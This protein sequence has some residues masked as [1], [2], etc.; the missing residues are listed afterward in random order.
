MSERTLS[1]SDLLALLR[2]VGQLLQAQHRQAAIYVVGGAAMALVFDARRVTRDVDMLAL[3][4]TDA[5]WASAAEVGRRH[6]LPDDWVNQNAAAFL[7]NEPD[8]S[9]HEVSLP[10]LRVLVASPEHLIAMKLRA[11]RDRDL[12][13]LD[14][15]FRHVGLTTPEQAAAIHDALFDESSIGFT[16]PEE[17]RYAAQIVFDR[18]KA[19]GN[20]IGG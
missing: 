6:S 1:G 13:D 2:E 3:A 12:A 18:A 5:F 10:G 11:L 14:L 15:L 4:E 17:A 9:P 20:P 7:S 16:G 8:T 19:R